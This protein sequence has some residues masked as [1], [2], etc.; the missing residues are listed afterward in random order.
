M[1]FGRK[2]SMESPPVDVELTGDMLDGAP[3]GGELQP[4][5]LAHLV[6][7]GCIGAREHHVKLQAR[8]PR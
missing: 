3:T 1:A 7:H 5:E 4:H 6:R 2:L 8:V